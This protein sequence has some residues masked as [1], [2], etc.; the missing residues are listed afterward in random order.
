MFGLSS[1]SELPFSTQENDA[2]VAMVGQSVD[3]KHR[4]LDDY[5]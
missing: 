1:F 5:R 3:T 4:N 2:A